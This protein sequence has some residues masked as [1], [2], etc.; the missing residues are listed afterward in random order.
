MTLEEI[1]MALGQARL[2]FPNVAITAEAFRMWHKLFEQEKA[3]DFH[4]A[5]LALIKQS[6]RVFFPTPGEVTEMLSKLNNNEP[7]GAELW[8]MACTLAQN[9]HSTEGMMEHMNMI[10][11]SAAQALKSIGWER[12][13]YGD[14]QRELP[15]VRRD[16]LQAL[17]EYKNYEQMEI[18][19]RDAQ[20]LLS[21]ISPSVGG[22]DRRRLE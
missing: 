14:F 7:C 10:S 20:S 2:V 3:A 1:T 8:E 22:V 19:N 18:S 4:A 17:E 6:G 13:R 21:K 11:P 15:F 5:I 9:G 16:F 12:V